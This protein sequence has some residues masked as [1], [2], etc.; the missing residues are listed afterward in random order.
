[1]KKK[2]LSFV[3][4]F[5]VGITVNAQSPTQNAN[6]QQNSSNRINSLSNSTGT[7]QNYRQGTN[8]SQDGVNSI[9][10]SQFKS[11]M[12]ENTA[13]ASKKVLLPV[14]ERSKQYTDALKQVINFSD[15]QYKKMLLANNVFITQIDQLGKSSKDNLSFQ[16]GLQEADKARVETYKTILDDK[17]LK[18]Y[19]DNPSLS[20]LREASIVEIK[21]GLI[22]DPVKNKTKT[23]SPDSLKKKNNKK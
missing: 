12:T 11:K 9:K 20:G 18:M 3:C 17:Q 5:T 1:M 6:S 4:A 7:S 21:D 22:T 16:R 13:L 10:G 14:T 8:P 19:L 23:I 2:I 15:V